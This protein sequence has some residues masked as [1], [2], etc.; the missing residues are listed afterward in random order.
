MN[1][2]LKEKEFY[3]ESHKDEKNIIERIEKALEKYNERFDVK[4]RLYFYHKLK[5]EMS[6]GLE[7]YIYELAINPDTDEIISDSE[8]FNEEISKEGY[9]DWFP[10][11]DLIDYLE[12]GKLY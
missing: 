1:E 2:Y 8:R 5:L 4:C 12:N 7:E 10:V 11:K 3:L 9:K 6:N